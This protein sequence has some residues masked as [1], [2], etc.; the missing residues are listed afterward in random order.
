MPGIFRK[1][2]MIYGCINTPVGVQYLYINRVV[3]RLYATV[4]CTEKDGVRQNALEWFDLAQAT[5]LYA[6]WESRS[7]VETDKGSEVAK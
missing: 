5:E 4:V 2:F 1:D 3:P 6:A 7:E